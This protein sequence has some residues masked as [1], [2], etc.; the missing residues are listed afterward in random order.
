MRGRVLLG[1]VC[2]VLMPFGARA[3]EVNVSRLRVSG[4]AQFPVLYV[5]VDNTAL[6]ERCADFDGCLVTLVA[7]ETTGIVA[8][9]ARMVL[10]ETTKVWTSTELGTSATDDNNTPSSALSAIRG[11]T[12]CGFGDTDGGANDSDVGFTF[13]AGAPGGTAGTCSLSIED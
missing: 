13:F 1:V 4:T 12:S 10:S 5:V 11:N 3:E 9:Q 2:L 7:E 8:K 6:R